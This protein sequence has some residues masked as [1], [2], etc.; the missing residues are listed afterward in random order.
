[1]AIPVNINL[2]ENEQYSIPME[3]TTETIRDFGIKRA[4]IVP[5]KIGDKIVSA[6]MVSCNK[7]QY[8]AYM[9]PIWAEMQREERS[10]RCMV[11]NGRGG[12]KRCDKDCK[13][14]DRM[15]NGSAFSMDQFYEQNNLEFN[16]PTDDKTDVILALATLEDLIAKLNAINPT[17][18]RVIKML[19]DGLSQRAIAAALGKPN[20]TAQ[21]LIRKTRLEAQR[22]VSREDLYR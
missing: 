6:I 15:K 4:D 9:R 20:S 2:N 10:L 3:V 16:E 5:A 1:M 11:S 14:C 7:E 12:L 8:Y 19:Y 17:Y 22:I 21:D 13:K 18:G